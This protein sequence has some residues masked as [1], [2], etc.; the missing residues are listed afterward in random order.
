M[1]QLPTIKVSEQIHLSVKRYRPEC[2][3][4]KILCDLIRAHAFTLRDVSLIKKLGFRVELVNN[5]P[6]E[7]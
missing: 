7:L 1:Q 2:E 4:S 6:T 5:T 3:L